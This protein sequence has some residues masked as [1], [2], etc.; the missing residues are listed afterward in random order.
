MF[1]AS[2]YGPI[3]LQGVLFLTLMTAI[4]YAQGKAKADLA[5][6]YNAGVLWILTI[7]FIVIIGTRPISGL[8]FVDM[9]TYAQTFENISTGGT[10]EWEDIGFNIFVKICASTTTV[11]GFFV[12]CAALYFIPVMLAVRRIHEAWALAALVA[13]TG[14]FSF[15]SYSVNGMRNGIA[16]SILLLAFAFYGRKFWMVSLMLLA[17]SMH[18]SAALPAVAFIVATICP[19]PWLFAVGWSVCLV[20][21]ILVGERLSAILANFIP[22]GDDE[23][24]STYLLSSG[25]GGDRGGFRADFILYS[26]VPVLISYAL[27]G[28]AAR[29]DIFYRKIVCCYLLSNATWLLMMYAAFSNR[30]AYLSWF[31]MPWVAIYPFIPKNFGGN[32]SSLADE[33]RPML[34]ASALV[35][36]YSFTYI[37]YTFVYA[38]RR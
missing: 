26:I 17:I 37:M 12:A 38:S 33:P 24:L 22:I 5:I 23:R 4:V 10:K 28:P 19:R 7:S 30:F 14:G 35:A 27:A 29:R 11:S 9:S 8:Y 2:L 36:H 18:K 32:K 21:S 34:L 25:L 13:F 16:C 1:D 6:N 31:M 3:Y 20:S 15:Y